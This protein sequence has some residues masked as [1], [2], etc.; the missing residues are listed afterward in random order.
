[1]SSPLTPI[2]RAERVIDKARELGMDGPNE[3]MIASIIADAE[4]DTLHFP[5][6]IRKRHQ[7]SKEEVRGQRKPITKEREL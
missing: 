6:T 3:A 5:N 4:W 7:L 2:E 1:M